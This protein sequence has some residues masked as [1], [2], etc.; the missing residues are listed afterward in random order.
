MMPDTAYGGGEIP[1]LGDLRGSC[2]WYGKS[3]RGI[4]LPQKH[5]ILEVHRARKPPTL[6]YCRLIARV[7]A[8]AQGQNLKQEKRK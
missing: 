1:L 2:G 4:R 7:G 5:S 6:V 3:G 8:A